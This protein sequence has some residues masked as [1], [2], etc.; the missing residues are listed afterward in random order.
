MQSQVPV[1]GV[2]QD[3]DAGDDAR[4]H[5]EGRSKSTLAPFGFDGCD[6]DP[7]FSPV[8]WKKTSSSDLSNGRSS[9]TPT[10]AFMSWRLISALFAGFVLRR[11]APSW[12]LIAA[13]PN[14][15]VSTS[16]ASSIG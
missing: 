7:C 13:A 10:P 1:D 14:M 5:E 12:R 8:S 6:H 16:C 9:L 4:R 3:R 15:R 2:D 11:M